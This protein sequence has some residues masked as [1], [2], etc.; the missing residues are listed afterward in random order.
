MYNGL[1]AMASH[2][3]A[4]QALTPGQLHM[5][6]H[7]LVPS[8]QELAMQGGKTWSHPVRGLRKSHFI[9]MLGAPWHVPIQMV[10]GS[11]S[12]FSDTH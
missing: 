5:T 1:I 11:L 3:L 6:S 12:G 2:M 8:K 10:H 4:D 9:L 7:E